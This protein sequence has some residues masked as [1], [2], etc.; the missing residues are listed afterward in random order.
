MGDCFF[1]AADG[2]D[3]LLRGKSQQSRIKKGYLIS[4]TASLI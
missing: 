2:K 1:A 3:D 4:K